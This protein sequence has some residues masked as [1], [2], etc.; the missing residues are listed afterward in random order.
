M[1]IQELGFEAVVPGYLE[2][3]S[4]LPSFSNSLTLSSGT[5]TASVISIKKAGTITKVSFRMGTTTNASNVYRLSIQTVVNGVP[6]GTLW[7]TN[8]EKTGITGISGAGTYVTVTLTAGAVVSAGDI[9]AVV[10][11]PTTV[12]GNS[13][14]SYYSDASTGSSGLPFAVQFNGSSWAVPA[15]APNWA[16]EY[17]DGTFVSILGLFSLK[18]IN[19]TN[20]NSSLMTGN[21][22][23][24]KKT[25][26]VVGFT[27]WA[28]LD[29]S[30]SVVIYGSDGSTQLASFALN[31]N[32]PI[33]STGIFIY[34]GYFSSP[35]TLSEGQTYYIMYRNTNATSVATYDYQTDSS[36]CRESLEG[37]EIMSRVTSTTINPTSPANF[38]E[39]STKLTSIGLIIDAVDF[40]TASSSETAFAFSC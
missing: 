1:A 29:A 26:R 10:F 3:S 7:A 28:D 20:A 12:V 11:Q 37:G 4:G 24:P 19:S 18:N 34:S 21:K 8:T 39:D 38:V 2:S 27:A 30:T 40:P 22:I 15:N 36:A 14:I 16:V 23:V 9:I 35:V 25:I 13:T 17:N 5:I 32:L 31:L 6:S 33:S